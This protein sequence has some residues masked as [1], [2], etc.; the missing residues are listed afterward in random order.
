MAEDQNT[1][2]HR[3]DALPDGGRIELQWSNGSPD[4]V[5]MTRLHLQ[6]MATRFEAGD[7]QIPGIVHDRSVPG[8]IIMAEKRDVITYTYVELPQG[9]EV[10][11]TTEDPYAIDA[12]HSFIAF[13]KE[14]HAAGGHDH[15]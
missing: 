5:A 8:T 14:E 13:Q 6:E 4:D 12:I 7:F 10:Y 1:A 3:F 11:I 2:T 15:P 9:G